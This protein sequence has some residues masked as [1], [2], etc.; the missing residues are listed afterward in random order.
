MSGL[1]GCVVGRGGLVAAA[2]RGGLVAAAARVF[3]ICGARAAQAAI[4]PYVSLGD[5]YAVDITRPFGTAGKNYYTA[6][7]SDPN[8]AAINAT[9]PNVAGVITA[10]VNGI[11]PTSAAYPLHLNQAGEQN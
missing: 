8:V 6:G 3:A 9:G 1:V 5:S 2:G 11:I 7:G 4:G 10:W